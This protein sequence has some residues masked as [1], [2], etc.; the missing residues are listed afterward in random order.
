M[1]ALEV[2]GRVVDGCHSQVDLSVDVEQ[3]RLDDRLPASQ[4]QVLCVSP[5]T[6]GLHAH[7]RIPAD[8]DAV[9]QHVIGLW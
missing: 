7:A 3:D 5:A 9:D 6:A 2:S 4:E 1:I 8:P